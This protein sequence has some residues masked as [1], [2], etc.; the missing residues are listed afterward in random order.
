MSPGSDFP[1]WS[2]IKMNKREG[3]GRGREREGRGGKDR[4]RAR[5][6][7]GTKKEHTGSWT[8]AVKFPMAVA[9]K[10]EVPII[11]AT[12]R[13]VEPCAGAGRIVCAE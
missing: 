13:S 4:A 3:E 5:E 1:D 6:T 8:F 12:S 10:G 7:K 11:L 9:L 2:V